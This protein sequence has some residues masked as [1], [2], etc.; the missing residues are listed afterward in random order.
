VKA[1]GQTNVLAECPLHNLSDAGFTYSGPAIDAMNIV[2]AK[3]APEFGD[4][5]T[6]ADYFLTFR[7]PAFSYLT[8]ALADPL[9]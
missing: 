5:S 8:G 1:S 9:F 6:D 4:N 3:L 2:L 7:N